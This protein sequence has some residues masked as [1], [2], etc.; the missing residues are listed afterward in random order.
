[1][2]WAFAAVAIAL[3]PQAVEA[4][5]AA[6]AVVGDARRDS[7]NGATLIEFELEPGTPLVVQSDTDPEFGDPDI[8]YQG[9]LPS[10]YVSGLPNGRYYFRARIEPQTEGA[11]PGDWSDV[12]TLDVAHHPLSR[13]WPVLGVGGLIFLA[14]CA[15]LLEGL[16]RT[17]ASRSATG[18]QRRDA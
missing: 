16:M 13:V 4:A 15:V 5:P 9:R 6:P 1:M 17:R 11:T 2:R 7:N 3:I 18:A 10:A 14:T 12:V 8:A